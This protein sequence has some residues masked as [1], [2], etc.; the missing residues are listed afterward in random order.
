[1]VVGLAPQDGPAPVQLL[2]QHYM[3]HLRGEQ[4]ET[5]RGSQS[6]THE[7]AELAE[8]LLQSLYAQARP[9]SGRNSSAS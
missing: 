9:A 1:M 2:Q 3:R 7:V 5:V 4:A 6:C 8:L